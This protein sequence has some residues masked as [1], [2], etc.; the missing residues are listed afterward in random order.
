MST[1]MDAEVKNGSFKA[2][3]GRNEKPVPEARGE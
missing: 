2:A 3:T 1:A